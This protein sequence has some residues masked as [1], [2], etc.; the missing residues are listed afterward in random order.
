MMV[1]IVLC[2]PCLVVVVSALIGEILKIL[3][4]RFLFRE[5]RLQTKTLVE[6]TLKIEVASQIQTKLV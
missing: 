1:V 5:L 6:G 3:L 4:A 2:S